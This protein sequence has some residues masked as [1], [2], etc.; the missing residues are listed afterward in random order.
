MVLY[1]HLDPV[2]LSLQ[3]LLVAFPYQQG[4]GCLTEPRDCSG[5]CGAVSS[6]RVPDVQRQI[7]D[8][9]S[10]A[11]PDDQVAT[12]AMCLALA[13]EGLPDYT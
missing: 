10:S 5:G 11:G 7:L 6:T 9:A 4:P 3:L 8:Q 13:Q 2:G 1:P 12:L